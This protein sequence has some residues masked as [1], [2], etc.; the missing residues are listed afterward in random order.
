MPYHKSGKYLTVFRNPKDACVSNHYY[1][2]ALPYYHFSG[3]FHDFFN[4]WIKG[5]IPYG[6]YFER[7]LSFWSHRFDDSFTFLTYE[8][9]KNNLR[10]AVLKI[11]Q[12]LEDEFGVKLKVKNE[13]LLNKVIENS[14]V[15]S[16]K[17]FLGQSFKHKIRK[18]IVGDWKN[19][20]N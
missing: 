11:G 2:R 15:D 19:H 6:D 13:F 7:V 16:T 5:G 18:G 20:F 12:F 9:M 17:S 14:T 4:S 10:D 8:E 1:V 3:D